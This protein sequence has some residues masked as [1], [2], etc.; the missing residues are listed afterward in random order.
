[1][2]ESE[3]EKSHTIGSIVPLKG[4][5]GPM[6]TARLKDTQ[7]LGRYKYQKIE[8][9]AYFTP[10]WCVHALLDHIEIHGPIWEPF[11]GEGRIAKE[12][13][14]RNEIVAC[15]DIKDYGYPFTVTLDFNH[16]LIAE[17]G[18]V[19][20]RNRTNNQYETPEWIVTNPPYTKCVEYVRELVRISKEYE[21]GLA[22]L[23]RNE[24]DCGKLRSDIFQDC[25][26]YFGKV[27]LTTRPVW[28]TKRNSDSDKSPRHNFSWYIWDF[29]RGPFPKKTIIYSYR[30][31]EPSRRKKAGGKRAKQPEE[32]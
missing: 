29:R 31:P 19:V 9:D 18:K 11:V 23:L 15:S 24:F 28:F 20:L 8:N 2:S 4:K 27:L 32:N 25:P 1:M 14:M 12:F 22:L 30:K 5:R 17:L 21:C 10:P 26:S 13:E 3:N 7:M 16:P 6:K